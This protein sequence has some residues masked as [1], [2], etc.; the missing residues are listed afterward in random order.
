[1]ATEP[2]TTDL[3]AAIDAA[4]TAD[5]WT[6]AEVRTPPTDLTANAWTGP[7]RTVHL[8]ITAAPGEPPIADLTGHPARHEADEIWLLSITDPTEHRLLAAARAAADH[9]LREVVTFADRL[10]HAGWTLEADGKPANTLCQITSADGR[11]ILTR[12]DGDQSVPGGWIMR[13]D[14]LDADATDGTP[15][16]VLHALVT[17]AGLSATADQATDEVLGSNVCAKPP[18][19]P[20]RQ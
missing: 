1:M 3:V 5:H 19:A 4:L 12:I 9:R 16:A 20:D 2:I 15:T 13:G 14:G 11:L 8:I 17:T 10:Q 18:M 7:D 6:R